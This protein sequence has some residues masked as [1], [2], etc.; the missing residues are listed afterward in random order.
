VP[1][2][3]V[4]RDG[5]FR[6]KGGESRQAGAH[7]QPDPSLSV[8]LETAWARLRAEIHSHKAEILLSLELVNSSDSSPV[9]QG[10]CLI[11]D[12]GPDGLFQVS[13]L[14]PYREYRGDDSPADAMR[15]FELMARVA[16]E[17]R[18][19]RRGLVGER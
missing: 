16:I 12:G 6:R 18:T 1:N 17:R 13:D 2:R 5:Q 3:S 4:F 14:G 9:I 10:D 7:P 19:Q 8:D 11:I 15:R